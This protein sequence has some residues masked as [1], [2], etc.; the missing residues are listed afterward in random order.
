MFDLESETDNKLLTNYIILIA[1]SFHGPNL[2]N[3]KNVCEN[4]QKLKVKTIQQV[5]GIYKI[6]MLKQRM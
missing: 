3:L 5:K 4:S 2:E 1:Q 6:K